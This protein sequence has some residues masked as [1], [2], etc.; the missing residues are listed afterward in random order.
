MRIA[1]IKLM[2][3]DTVVIGRSQRCGARPITIAVSAARHGNLPANDATSVPER[4]RKRQTQREHIVVE[5]LGPELKC[6]D[7]GANKL[8]SIESIAA[9][10]IEQC[11]FS[12][13]V[14]GLDG[15]D[16]VPSSTCRRH[17]IGAETGL[18][19]ECLELDSRWGAIGAS[20]RGRRRP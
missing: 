20:V 17:H 2:F 12:V 18:L 4:G 14:A 6:F 9:R 7:P 16:N 5:R 10:L 11:F 8:S 15:T 19:E 13:R 3:S 1:R